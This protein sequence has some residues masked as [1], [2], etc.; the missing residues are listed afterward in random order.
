MNDF[1]LVTADRKVRKDAFYF[2]KALWNTDDPFVYVSE[3]RW[4]ERPSTTQS[5][6]VFSNLE[7]VELFVNGISAGIRRDRFVWDNLTFRRGTNI[8]EARAGN[9][10]D[11]VSIEITASGRAI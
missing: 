10:S 11:K 7:E 5:I 8:I 4:I 9:F 1:G 2:Y 3:R 6:T